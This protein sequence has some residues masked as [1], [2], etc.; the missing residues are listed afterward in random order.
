MGR[1]LPPVLPS[2]PGG[3]K[4]RARK[5]VTDLTGKRRDIFRAKETHHLDPVPVRVQDIF[6][7]VVREAPLERHAGSLKTRTCLL[8]VSHGDGKVA[9]P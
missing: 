2:C 5:Y 7:P 8:D 3:G 1:R 9:E 6:H 4:V